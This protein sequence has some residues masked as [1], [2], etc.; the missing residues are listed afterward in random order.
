[1]SVITRIIPDVTKSCS[2]PGDHTPLRGL[3]SDSQRGR[4]RSKKMLLKKKKKKHKQLRNIANKSDLEESN[5]SPGQQVMTYCE[6]EK[7]FT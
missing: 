3:R 2:A 6:N 4:G 1:M 5:L 7:T